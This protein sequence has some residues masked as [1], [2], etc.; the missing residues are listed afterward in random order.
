MQDRLNTLRTTKQK[1]CKNYT[2]KSRLARVQKR[3][4]TERFIWVPCFT[5]HNLILFQPFSKLLLTPSIF[6]HQFPS[7]S[8]THLQT[9]LK[10]NLTAATCGQMFQGALG[11]DPCSDSAESHVVRK[12]TVCPAVNARTRTIQVFTT[13]GKFSTFQNNPFSLNRC[14]LILLSQFSIGISSS[15]ALERL[16]GNKTQHIPVSHGTGL[17]RTRFHAVPR[18]H[19]YTMMPRCCCKPT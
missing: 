19:T 9:G 18:P 2:V 12:G 15:T 13:S 4:N 10:R 11:P 7:S 6:T 16:S 14:S 5:L 17:Q 1:A 8:F 3:E